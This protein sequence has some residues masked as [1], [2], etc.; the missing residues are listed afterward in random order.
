M[1]EYID[2]P[3][4][5]LLAGLLAE[6]GVRRIVVSP[7]SRCAPL[8]LALSRS[9]RFDIRVII[10]ER[11]AAFAGLGMALATDEPVALVCTSGSAVLNYAPALA[12]AFYR[13]VPLIAVSADRPADMIDIR[14]SQTIRQPGALAAVVR[15]SVDIADVRSPREL[16]YANRLMNDAVNA[17]LGR[18]RGP[19]HINMQFDAPLTPA[20]SEKP[21][22]YARRI[23]VIVP[24]AELRLDGVLA[25]ID[26]HARVLVLVAAAHP[27]ERFARSAAR[28]A[29]EG[30]IAILA[31]AQANL[32]DVPG[33]FNP[34]PDFSVPAA[35]D[36]VVTA[37]GSLCS[38][39]L[40][41]Y[42][43]SLP[44]LRHIS[45]GADDNLND[46]F[47]VLAETV[48]CDEGAFLEALAAHVEGDAAFATGWRECFGG[49]HSACS[50]VSATIAELVRRMPCAAFHFSNGM[51][52]RYAQTVRFG[53][54]DR[55]EANRGVSGIE[56]A[57]STAIGYAMASDRPVVLVS[58]DMSAAYDVG[59][60]AIAGIPA[61]FRMMVVDNGGGD[62]FRAVR[63]T[64][65]LPETERFFATP[66]RLPLKALA[67][68]YG[69]R[70]CDNI[71]DFINCSDAPA[72]FR[73][74]VEAGDAN[75]II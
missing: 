19:V 75:N 74:V 41:S 31:E 44:H 24:P 45:L 11:S 1:E 6:A 65:G 18:V 72:I 51:S 66:P 32:H 55:V 10:D 54:A 13:R 16:R 59:A 30:R 28:I 23:P 2:K 69:F 47:G 42:L 4:A 71:D 34:K 15:S 20:T 43:R 68:A 35:P 58:G 70:Y 62:I 7:G 26:R 48:D 36:I 40:K 39:A 27:S 73:L 53:T 46:T 29:R 5:G 8:V 60:L 61:H 49:D 56:G 12:E 33:F 64:R 37:G 38:A 63:T 52:V 14:D 21:V 9:G 22:P 25:G 57:T 3:T 67:E 50:I 17:A